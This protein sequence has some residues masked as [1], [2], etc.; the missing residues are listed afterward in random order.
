MKGMEEHVEMRIKEGAG[1]VASSFYFQ[2]PPEKRPLEAPMISSMP[3]FHLFHYISLKKKGEGSDK[4]NV[5][6]KKDTLQDKHNRK[7]TAHQQEGPPLEAP[8]ILFHTLLPP[9]PSSMACCR[10]DVCSNNTLG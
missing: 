3:P 8:M 4:E 7:K 9:L 1:R 10:P 2:Q 6:D 5:K